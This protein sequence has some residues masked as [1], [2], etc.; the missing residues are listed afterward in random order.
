MSSVPPIECVTTAGVVAG[1]VVGQPSWNDDA[2]A[3]LAER[4]LHAKLRQ[5]FFEISP[6]ADFRTW[7]ER[8]ARRGP[9][10]EYQGHGF[11]LRFAIKPEFENNLK[12][13][14]DQLPNEFEGFELW[15]E[16]WSEAPIRETF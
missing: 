6:D 3:Q 4:T 10:G 14:I 5:E 9:S 1:G 7:F 12:G 13:V 15:S 8:S 11:R 16:G 2:K